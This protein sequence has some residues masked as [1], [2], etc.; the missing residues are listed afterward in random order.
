MLSVLPIISIITWFSSAAALRRHIVQRS[1]LVFL[2]ATLFI[3]AVGALKF[4]VI[5]G[6][7]DLFMSFQLSDMARWGES[8]VSTFLFQISP[9]ITIAAVASLFIAAKKR[10]L[11]YVIVV[12]LPFLIILL[13][14]KRIRYLFPVF[15]MLTLMASYGLTALRDRTHKRVVIA[16]IVATSLV[17]CF[18]VYLPYLNSWSAVNLK[19]AGEFLNTLDTIDTVE[20]FTIPQQRY[21]INPAIAVPLLDLFTHKKIVYRYVPGSSTPDEDARQSRFRFSW[22]YR[23]PDYYTAGANDTAGNKAVAL[24]FRRPQNSVPPETT[25]V[26]AGLHHSASFTT[27]NPLFYY[28]TLV[29]IYW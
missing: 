11:R 13:Q 18:F 6:Q 15:P 14:I 12:W 23:N 26:I 20:V 16:S 8:F 19:Q 22:E 7:I 1:L 17:T 2:P 21:P 29:R 9:V 25:D 24:I 3:G 27:F 28:Q 5:A 4:D 10:D